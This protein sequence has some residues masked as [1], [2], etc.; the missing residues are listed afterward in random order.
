[1][2][3]VQLQ[4]M[5]YIV[6]HLVWLCEYHIHTSIFIVSKKIQHYPWIN[7]ATNTDWKLFTNPTPTHFVWLLST[8]RSGSDL[9]LLHNTNTTLYIVEIVDKYYV[10]HLKYFVNLSRLVE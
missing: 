1:M 9:I 3:Y 10:L 5:S 6:Y 7:E 4:H 8:V 2:K